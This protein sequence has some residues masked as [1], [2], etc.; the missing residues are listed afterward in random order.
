[1]V[2]VGVSLGV[3]VF[4]IVGILLYNRFKSKTTKISPTPSRKA[5]TYQQDEPDQQEEYLKQKIE[6]RVKIPRYLL[7]LS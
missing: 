2:P 5:K 1:M 6:I 3:T 4:G 7:N